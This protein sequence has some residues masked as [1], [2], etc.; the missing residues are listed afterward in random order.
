MGLL[1]SRLA[2]EACPPAVSLEECEVLAS[3]PG[4][5]DLANGNPRRTPLQVAEATGQRITPVRWALKKLV[6]RELAG[7]LDDKGHYFRTDTG[8]T[9][10]REYFAK[11]APIERQV[12][13][14]WFQKDEDSTYKVWKALFDYSNLRLP[15]GASSDHEARALGLQMLRVKFVFENG[16]RE[17]RRSRSVQTVISRDDIGPFLRLS[18]QVLE[19]TVFQVGALVNIKPE[20]SVLEIREGNG[21][22]AKGRPSQAG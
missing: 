18:D 11:L 14:L 13:R 12:G 4:K 19:G 17:T 5:A 8:D 6:K 16:R 1:A 10:V 20:F 9:T 3:L 22:K 7:N 15:K 21:K 2:E